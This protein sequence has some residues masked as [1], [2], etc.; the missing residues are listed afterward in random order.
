MCLSED[1]ERPRDCCG[2]PML[3]MKSVVMDETGEA[4]TA[5]SFLARTIAHILVG[6]LVTAIAKAIFRQKLTVAI[7]AG[8]LALAVHHNFDAPVARKLS[9]LGL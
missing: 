7:V 1:P 6:L 9:K 3:V 2:R 8:L 4:A 5:P